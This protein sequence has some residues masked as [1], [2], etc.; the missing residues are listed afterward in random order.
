M[1]IWIIL[2]ATLSIT[3]SAN[4]TCIKYGCQQTCTANKDGIVECSCYFEYM[5]DPNNSTACLKVLPYVDGVK[6]Y[7]LDYNSDECKTNN[8]GCDHICKNTMESFICSCRDG[9]ELGDNG[10]SCTFWDWYWTLIIIFIIVVLLIIVIV[11]CCL[12]GKFKWLSENICCKCFIS[13]SCCITGLFCKC[14]RKSEAD[15]TDLYYHEVSLKVAPQKNYKE[16]V[17][18]TSDE[19]V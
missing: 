19:G 13:W 8:G 11:V 14:N 10:K 3:E 16:E 15:V 9:Y 6:Q 1:M 5:V 17:H 18:L 12:C 4:L 7:L 2:L